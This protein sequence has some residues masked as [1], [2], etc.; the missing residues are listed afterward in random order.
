LFGDRLSAISIQLTS[1]T[2]RENGQ[3]QKTDIP[4]KKAPSCKSHI[5]PYFKALSRDAG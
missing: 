5:L 1:T 4:K 3:K 2:T